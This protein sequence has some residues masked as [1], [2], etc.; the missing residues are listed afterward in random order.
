MVSSPGE[1][2]QRASLGRALDT[3]LKVRLLGYEA[4]LQQSLSVVEQGLGITK[5]GHAV[6]KD[7]EQHISL[8][9]NLK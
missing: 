5:L 9:N 4:L 3:L 7:N 8:R 6:L 2:Q 1:M